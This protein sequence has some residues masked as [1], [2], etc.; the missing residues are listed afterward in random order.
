MTLVNSEP[1]P[2][3]MTSASAIAVRAA[4][5]G[6]TLPRDAGGWTVIRVRLRLMR[7]SPT[8][9]GAVFERGF[10]RHVGGGAGIDASGDLE[11]FRGGPHGVRK[12]A[13][14]LRQRHQEQVAE[15]VAL[16]PAA[17]L[18]TVLEQ[19]REQRGILAQRHH[20]VADVAGRQHVELAAQASGAAAVVGDGDDGGDVH[21]GRR[22]SH[23]PG[24]VF[25]PLRAA[26]DR[27]VPPPMATTRRGDVSS[28]ELARQRAGTV[29]SLSFPGRAAS[30]R[31][32]GWP[33]ARSRRP[34]A[35]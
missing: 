13:H 23:A 33:A 8:T 29:T 6:W 32:A 27:P 11:H 14:D 18:E 15:A 5:R 34:A 30:R 3:V 9:F 21:R 25:E 17:G 20:A 7:V 31:G 19:A 4:G 10:E 28:M 1:G 22:G 35:R 16:E 24:V 2:R 12:I 26:L